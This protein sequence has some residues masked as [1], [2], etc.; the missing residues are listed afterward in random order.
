MSTTVVSSA[1][2]TPAKGLSLSGSLCLVAVAAVLVAVS[3]PR[4]RG[5][6]LQENEVDA[7]AMALLLGLELGRLPAVGA[8]PAIE[9]L[10]QSS[11]EVR[12]LADVE[13]LEEGI[14]LRRHG[15]LF[16]LSRLPTSLWLAYAF[17]T[18]AGDRSRVAVRAWPWKH[19]ATGGAAFL[20]TGAGRIYVHPNSPPLWEGMRARTPD[21]P[22]SGWL[23]LP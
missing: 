14:L 18:P 9:D 7:R 15:Y 8:P 23:L 1:V 3:L 2:P 21:V 16:E 5:I 17:L 6:A 10:V 20:V 11:K 22:D 4:L 12:A 19:G 13:L